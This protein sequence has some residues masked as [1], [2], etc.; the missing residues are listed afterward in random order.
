[1]RKKKKSSCC[2]IFI[3]SQLLE[4]KIYRKIITIKFIYRKILN[5][6][7]IEKIYR[8]SITRNISYIGIYRKAYSTRSLYI[9]KYIESKKNMLAGIPAFA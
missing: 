7:H 8:N 6:T 1:M 3:F 4:K 2:S 5:I 9:S